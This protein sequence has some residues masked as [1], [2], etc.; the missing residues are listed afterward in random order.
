VTAPVFPAGA[1]EFPND[2]PLL[3]DGARWICPET[4]G[5][6]RALLRPRAGGTAIPVVA[7]ASGSSSRREPEVPLEQRF[8]GPLELDLGRILLVH[9][10]ED[11]PP[12]PEFI[13]R[14]FVSSRRPAV[15]LTV[16]EAP[17]APAAEAS[18]SS[19]ELPTPID[20]VPC[21]V[22]DEREACR[23]VE[24]G[25]RVDVAPCVNVGANGEG[26]RAR[27]PRGIVS[28]RA[29]PPSIPAASSLE[30]EIYQRLISA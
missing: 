3:H 28:V 6:V 12:P 20:P 24:R 18:S 14:P 13:F 27:V 15:A 30:L 9:R 2:N 8:E 7:A 4:V 11:I 29:L 16:V 21:R 1:A 22:I 19:V 5:P 26:L 10:V 23:R 17:E 25:W